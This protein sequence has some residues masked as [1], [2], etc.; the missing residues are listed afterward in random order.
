MTVLREF[1][2]G[3]PEDRVVL[4]LAT[5]TMTCGQLLTRWSDGM[6]TA[7]WGRRVLLDISRLEYAL[8]ALAQLDG[9]A[10][11]LLLVSRS[12]PPQTIAVLGERAGCDVLL[13]DGN[14]LDE[15]PSQWK[16]Y[17]VPQDLDGLA[18][19]ASPEPRVATEWVLPTSGT[20]G[21]PK[22]VSHSLQ[23]LT[24]TTRVDLQRGA[25]CR[26]GL[27]Y[28]Y[29][30]F[31]GLQVVLQALLPGS[32]LIAP[33]RSEPLTEQVRQLVQGGCTHL[34]ATPTLWRK[35]L[36]TEGCE[37]LA[38]RQITLG[39]E[40]AE[41][42]VLNALRVRFP[43]ARITHIYASTE[44]GVGFSVSD[45]QEGFPASYVTEPPAGIELRV[46]G[47]KLFVRNPAVQ[48]QYVGTTDP[49]ADEQGFVD[50]C[51]IVDLRGDRYV[52]LGR[53]T[54]VINV[55]GNKVHPEEVEHV[56]LS[57]PEVW[58]AKVSA[59]KNPITGALVVAEVVPLQTASDP[60]ALRDSI[61]QH[62]LA[63]L[64]RHKVPALIR[65]VKELACSATGKLARDSD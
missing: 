28:D 3:V 29:V 52:F 45:G 39:G 43:E 25:K 53:E 64:E 2:R 46:R 4:Q 63:Q 60:A 30:R 61:T 1:L 14:T 17:R 16:R 38:L 50:T 57:H 36:M 26:W 5:G 47:G 59:K 48:P 51:D 49:F 23:S 7:L 62:C 20:T 18:G 13:T 10:S 22:L 33:L 56:L 54:G 12:I 34:S 21:T 32:L 35:I 8:P 31:A 44:A 55:G 19:S 15:I 9:V 37:R 41:A 40:V 58:Q 42:R 65:F 6:A 11:L 24:R 27:L